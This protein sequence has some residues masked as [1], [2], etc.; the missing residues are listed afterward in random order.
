MATKKR[1]RR[2]H[3]PQFGGG[4]PHPGTQQQDVTWEEVRLDYAALPAD[5]D[6]DEPG[7][8]VFG[9][10]SLEC[11]Q[12]DLAREPEDPEVDRAPQRSPVRSPLWPDGDRSREAWSSRSV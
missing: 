7:C 2:A 9:E 11:G 6:E 1:S 4:R 8:F 3:K 12:S 5:L 10:P